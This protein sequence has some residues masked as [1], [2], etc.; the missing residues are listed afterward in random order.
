[1]DHVR[2]VADTEAVPDVDPD[3]EQA[4]PIVE[5]ESP[6]GVDPLDLVFFGDN[7]LRRVAEPVPD[8]SGHLAAL[9]DRMLV[10]M[11][12]EAGVGLAAPQVGENVRMLVHAAAGAPAQVLVN[13][14]IVES[15][16][17]WVYQEG[18]LSIPG[19]YYDVVRPKEIHIRAHDLDG[20][21]LDFDADEFL[22]RVCLHEIDHLDGIV[23]V[24]RLEADAR[25]LALAE[26]RARVAG[27]LG[28]NDPFLTGRRV[29]GVKR[30][31]V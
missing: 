22:A 1:M 21:E 14:E 17:E 27:T 5:I 20:N 4:S 6:E 19:L 29:K 8:V 9:A 11:Q 23:F 10:T 3:L 25:E 31:L 2:D 24:D 15:R 18:C 30:K 7:T 13:P 26:L 16:G 12:V 28:A